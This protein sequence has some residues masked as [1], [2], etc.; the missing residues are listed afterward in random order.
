MTFTVA[1]NLVL[2]AGLIIFLARLRGPTFAL[3]KQILAGLLA[4]VVFEI[5]RASCRE[6]V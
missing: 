5:G 4:G 1:I 2:F 3:S 6:R